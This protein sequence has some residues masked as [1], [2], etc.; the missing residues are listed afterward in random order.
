MD[1]PKDGYNPIQI[2]LWLK[3]GD[4]K[5]VMWIVDQ[6]IIEPF[7]VDERVKLNNV[8]YCDF[9]PKLSLHVT[10]SNFVVSKWSEY[11]CITMSLIKYLCLPV[12]PFKHER[13]TW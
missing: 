11:L 5:V 3:V 1:G 12:K 13:F 8:I 4:N 9:M 10:R 2:C 7:K 6:T